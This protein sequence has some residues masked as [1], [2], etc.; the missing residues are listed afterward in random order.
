MILNGV[1]L[2]KLEKLQLKTNKGVGEFYLSN[3]TVQEFLNWFSDNINAIFREAGLS[4]RC[5]IVYSDVGV[6]V[7]V[8]KR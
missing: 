2:L 1:E 3:N 8:Q 4:G 6:V 7:I 5:N